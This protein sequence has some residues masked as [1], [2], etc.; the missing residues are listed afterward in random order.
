[1]SQ[2]K[3]SLFNIK[4]IDNRFISDILEEVWDSLEERGYNPSNQIVG[5]L[6]SGDPGYI[7]SYQDARTKIQQVDRA[8]IIEVLL[9]EFY[10]NHR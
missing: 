2:D 5:Y 10:K 1:M 7:S 6:I 4:D 8:K 3:T 9:Q